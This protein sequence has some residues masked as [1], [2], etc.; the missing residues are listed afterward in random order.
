M[1]PIA[2]ADAALRQGPDGTQLRGPAGPGGPDRHW[3]LDN[4]ASIYAPSG[5]IACLDGIMGA[6]MGQID[7]LTMIS[8]KPPEGFK[9]TPGMVGSPI[10]LD[11]SD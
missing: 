7:S 6:A 2:Q 1:D 11:S 5:A 10:D 9:D 8:S 4:G 3:P